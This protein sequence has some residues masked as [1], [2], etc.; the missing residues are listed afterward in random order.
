MDIL[1]LFTKS[2]TTGPADCAILIACRR[3]LSDSMN[4][5]KTTCKLRHNVKMSNEFM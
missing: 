1:P 4:S 3:A 2:K 5:R